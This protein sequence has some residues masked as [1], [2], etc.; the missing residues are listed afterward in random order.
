M[1]SDDYL[2]LKIQEGEGYKVEYKEKIANLDREI[3]AFANAAGGEIFLGVDDNGE[4]KGIDI[5]NAL[6]SQI[7]DIARNCDP[8][9]QIHLK[10]CSNENV[11]IVQI[12]EGQ[13][14]P[15]K[16]KD[17]FFLRVGPNS[18]KL[19][20]DEI[21]QFI[22]NVGKIHFDETI[23]R[24]FQY[25]K[26]FSQEAFHHYLK[27]CGLELKNR[28]EDILLSLN[29][30]DKTNASLQMT[31]AGVLFFAQGPQTFFPEAYVT[32]VRYQTND[33]FSIIDKKDFFGSPITQIEE[34]L[35][36]VLRHMNVAAHFDKKAVA[37][38]QDIYDYPPIAIREA[39]INAITHR[40]Y[41]YDGAHIYIHMY[42]EYI[43]IENPGGLYHGLTL[44]DLGHRSVRRN[45]LI[46]DILHRARYIERV[47][48]GFDRMKIALEENKNPPFEVMATNFFNIRFFK[49]A[50]DFNLQK[51]TSRQLAMYY[52]LL[53]HKKMSKKE[54]ALALKVSEDTAIRELRILIK[55]GLIKKEGEGKATRYFF[56][57]QG[58]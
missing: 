29:L 56:I 46:A 39:I 25:S 43:D 23:N 19:K 27:H 4:V 30:A 8:S 22:N 18:Q 14:K 7:V 52:L 11:L 38:R 41:L 57:D 35:A 45:R 53:E 12:D 20:R 5:T 49:R 31:N 32:A 16:C 10:K 48:S 33:R 54:I 3:V 40:D 47:G 50:P 28:T 26:D 34:S 15:Y 37:T 6:Q 42:P 51:L 9:I 24:K 55:N 21:I 44:E 1:N 17:G 58:N 13:N 36:F 2:K